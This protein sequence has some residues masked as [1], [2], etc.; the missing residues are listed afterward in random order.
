MSLDFAESYDRATIRQIKTPRR[1]HGGPSR[2]FCNRS[3]LD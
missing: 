1:S 3:S 2:E